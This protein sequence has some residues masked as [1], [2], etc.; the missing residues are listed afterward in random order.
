MTILGID[1]GYATVGIG[2]LAYQNQKF[3]LLEAKPILTAPNVCFPQRLAQIYEETAAILATHRPDAAA[4]ER[5]YFNTNNKTAIDVAQA[6]GVL[7]LCAQQQRVPVFEYT[8][9]QV[10]QS[11]AGYGRAEKKQIQEMVRILLRL[12]TCP[13]PDDVADALALAICHAHTAGSLLSRV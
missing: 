11:V 12:N 6:R 13:K 4:V 2:V 1:P 8:P 7:V 3:Q 5:L 9:L 10:K